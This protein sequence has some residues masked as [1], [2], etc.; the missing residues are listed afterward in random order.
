MPNLKHNNGLRERIN[1]Q[2]AKSSKFHK[3]E[4]EVGYA[5]ISLICLFAGSVVISGGSTNGTSLGEN[6]AL[7]AAQQ[8][9]LDA[10]GAASDVPAGKLK[11]LQSRTVLR[12][13]I[14]DQGIFQ[15]DLNQASVNGAAATYNFNM[16]FVLPFALPRI[17]RPYDTALPMERYTDLKL[18]IIQGGSD[19]QYSGNDRA[20]D[21]S[22]AY[23]DIHEKRELMNGDYPFGVLYDDDRY[24]PI[25]Q[26]SK[27]MSVFGELPQGEAYID[28]LWMAETTNAALADTI[29]NKVNLFT[30]TMQWSEQESNAIK[31]D[32]VDYLRTQ[33]TTLTGLYY[34]PVVQGLEKNNGLLAGAQ[35]G[36]KAILDVSNPAAGVDRLLVATRRIAP[37]PKAA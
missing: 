31:D 10:T 9:D 25:V 18:K 11:S 7:I 30:G 22:A 33:S 17:A 1:F 20:F 24:I 4:L 3:I 16:P 23:W 19:I 29:I 8:F 37:F 32:M 36:L 14:L 35:Y 21:Y 34:T 15:S 27:K 13:R 6:P 26:A 5:L 2:S 12:R 28:A